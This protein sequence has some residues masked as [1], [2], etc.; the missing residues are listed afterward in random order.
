[1]ILGLKGQARVGKNTVAEMVCARRN[2]VEVA[3]ADPFK[4]F[5]AKVFGFTEAQLWGDLRDEPDPR[6]AA[7]VLHHADIDFR[8]GG[9]VAAFLQELLPYMSALVPEAH[10]SLERW[11][12]A[13]GEVHCAYNIITPRIVLQT[14]GT[15][16]G[17]KNLSPTVWH[18][19]AIAYAKKLLSGGWTYSRTAG[20]A[21]VPDFPGYDIVVISD[22][23]FRNEMIGVTAIG[24]K[25]L[26]IVDPLVH[27]AE[28]GVAG[29]P[30]ERQQKG[31]PA[32]WSN[33]VL[34]NDKR[35]GLEALGKKVDTALRL[36]FPEPAIIRVT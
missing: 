33:L 13:L 6:G 18:D 20:M 11:L 12:F 22:I 26:E 31:V 8:L 27:A 9:H 23:R 14:L 1:M 36:L 4:R 16:W 34:V 35:D 32:W 3:Q 5:V 25:L 30:S 21:Y 10:A 24:G 7:T 15:E 29:H 17:R 28:Y 2:G 19:I